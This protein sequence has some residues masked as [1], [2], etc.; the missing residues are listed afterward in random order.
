MNETRQI[1][2]CSMSNVG[3]R[4]VNEVCAHQT[5]RRGWRKRVC[6]GTRNALSNRKQGS[7]DTLQCYR[8]LLVQYTALLLSYR[9]LL[10]SFRAILDVYRALLRTR[11]A[12]R[13]KEEGV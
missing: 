12:V 9:A 1:C 4:H 5:T 13:M 10:I 6:T 11:R 8:A 3:V 7:L 2:E